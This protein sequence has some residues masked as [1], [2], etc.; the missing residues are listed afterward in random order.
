MASRLRSRRNGFSTD[1]GF[2]VNPDNAL[3]LIMASNE[4][5]LRLGVRKSVFDEAKGSAFATSDKIAIRITYPDDSRDEAVLAYFNSYIRILGGADTAYLL[6]QHRDTSDTYDL[7]TADDGTI[8]SL[9]FFTVDGDGNATTTPFLTHPVSLK[10]WI[11]WNVTAAPSNQG[12][13]QGRRGPGE[14]ATAGDLQSP[15]ADADD[16]HAAAGH[17]GSSSTRGRS[18]ST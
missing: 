1:G 18:R 14:A 6:F 3:S 15:V 7:Y 13:G 2:S 16:G 17:T 8:V 4:G 9:D 11:H 10:H 5:R 12:N